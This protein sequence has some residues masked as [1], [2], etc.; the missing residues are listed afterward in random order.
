MNA[1]ILIVSDVSFPLQSRGQLDSALSISN[2]MLAILV[3]K[4]SDRQKASLGPSDI[5]IEPALGT[6]A[7]TDFTIAAGTIA[8]GEAAARAAAPRL[9]ALR[10]SDE[11]LCGLYG[12]ACDSRAGFAGDQ[13]RA[14]RS[15]LEA[16]RED[17]S[18][19]DAAA[20][21]QAVGS[22]R[23]R[24][25]HHRT[26]R[27]RVFRDLGLHRG[28]PGRGSGRGV[29]PRGARAPQ[30]LGPELRAL[31]LE[32]AG[33]FSGQQSVQRGGALFDDRDRRL[34]ARSC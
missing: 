34:W 15:G 14:G 22:G 2:Q 21:R 30:V 10:V 8:Q 16:L 17:H 19:R 7:A 24:R 32:P 11:R 4:D 20:G 18:R 5:L 28:H 6:A 27:P 13:I 3:R 29:R 33:R 9:A 31:R 23:G 12:A 26:V 25:A 1:D